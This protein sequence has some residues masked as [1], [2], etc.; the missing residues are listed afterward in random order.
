MLFANH[1]CDGSYNF[2]DINEDSVLT[3]TNVG[4]DQVPDKFDQE[5]FV[6]SPVIERRIRQ[7][8]SGVGTEESALRDIKAGEEILMNY[9]YYGANPDHW[10]EFV[11]DLRDQCLGEVT[12]AI[13]KYEES[14]GNKNPIEKRS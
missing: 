9:L 13:T 1:G 3:E 4:I 7:Y 8:L 12:G 11:S 14:V 2:G 6:Y 10:K 5:A